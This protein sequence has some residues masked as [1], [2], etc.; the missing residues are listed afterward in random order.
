MERVS[1][2]EASCE[3]TQHKT[4]IQHGPA[5]F[6]DVPCASRKFF[7]FKPAMLSPAWPHNPSKYFK[8]QPLDAAY[9]RRQHERAIGSGT[10]GSS[11][12]GVYDVLTRDGC[13]VSIVQQPLTG[14]DEDVAATERVLD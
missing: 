6:G 5:W 4:W 7:E 10:D 3:S 2:L 11:W 1:A 9:D 13:R 8:A 14:F 12:R